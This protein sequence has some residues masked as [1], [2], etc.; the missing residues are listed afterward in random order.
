M[1]DTKWVLGKWTGVYH[2][3][4]ELREEIGPQKRR[5][6]GS[7]IPD[8]LWSQINPPLM[9]WSPLPYSLSVSVCLSHTHTH[10]ECTVHSSRKRKT[11]ADQ[12]F[13]L[14]IQFIDITCSQETLQY[15]RDIYKVDNDNVWT[16]IFIAYQQSGQCS[17]CIQCTPKP[18]LTWLGPFSGSSPT[19]GNLIENAHSWSPPLLPLEIL[20]L[21]FWVS[22][23]SWQY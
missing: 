15:S 7:G 12:L 17:G 11:T 8:V 2:Y 22:L 14:G 4:S 21:D 6:S 18:V 9:M 19:V 3:E 1:L 10:I 20:I 5:I 13:S 23:W 16:I